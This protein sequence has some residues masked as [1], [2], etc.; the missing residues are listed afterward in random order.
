MFT[1]DGDAFTGPLLF[2]GG[3]AFPLADADDVLLEV[4]LLGVEAQEAQ[5]QLSHRLGVGR[6]L[7]E[8]SVLQGAE[9]QTVWI[10]DFGKRTRRRREGVHR[11]THQVVGII[12]EESVPA[13]H[14]ALRDGRTLEDLNRRN[15]VLAEF[16]PGL[17]Q[18]VGGATD[19]AEADTSCRT[20]MTGGSLC[21]RK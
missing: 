15:T 7:R 2:E 21:W 10:L 12:A 19:W 14:H 11:R 4:E 6:R 5:P 9:R 8:E 20:G 16:R 17:N 18:C 13:V 1:F 3:E